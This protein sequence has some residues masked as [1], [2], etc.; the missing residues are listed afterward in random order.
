MNLAM[1]LL[2]TVVEFDVGQQIVIPVSRREV[3]GFQGVNWES[4]ASQKK[5]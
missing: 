3:Y 1:K 2:N 4:L 5:S